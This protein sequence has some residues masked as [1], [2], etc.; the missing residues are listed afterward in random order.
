VVVG[1]GDKINDQVQGTGETTL[2]RGIMLTISSPSL[3]STSSISVMRS[4]NSPL[5]ASKGPSASP[6]AI[7]MSMD[8]ELRSINQAISGDAE[9]VGKEKCGLK[10]YI[11]ISSRLSRC[12]R[13]ASCLRFS[14]ALAAIVRLYKPSLFIRPFPSLLFGLISELINTISRGVQS[15][16]T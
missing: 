8:A 1:L 6:L 5:A 12:R 16:H 14:P 11:I 2:T 9:Q 13:S 15:T 7:L 4:S 10:A 3:P